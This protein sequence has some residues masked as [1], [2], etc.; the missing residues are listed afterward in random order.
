[1]RRGQKDVLKGYDAAVKMIP[2]KHGEG[3]SVAQETVAICAKKSFGQMVTEIPLACAA[4]CCL[5]FARKTV[6]DEAGIRRR[7]PRRSVSFS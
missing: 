3:D 2:S 5:F 6:C 1:V 4:L 7:R